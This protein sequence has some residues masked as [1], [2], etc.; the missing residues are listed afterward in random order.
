M[1]TYS[2]SPNSKSAKVNEEN[3]I[4]VEVLEKDQNKVDD[5]LE[6]QADKPQ[7]IKRKYSS[8][9]KSIVCKWLVCRKRKKVSKSKPNVE[10]GGNTSYRRY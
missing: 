3:S 7:L 10:V 1:R 8:Q 4:V 9:W 6:T 5:R 2:H